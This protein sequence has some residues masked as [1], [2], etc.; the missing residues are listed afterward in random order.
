MYPVYLRMADG[1]ATEAGAFGGQG[2]A[3][4]DRPQ[5]VKV[6]VEPG[7]AAFKKLM[8]NKVVVRAEVDGLGRSIFTVRAKG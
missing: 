2:Q 3:V 5:L 7:D 8:R 6:D 4:G 1:S